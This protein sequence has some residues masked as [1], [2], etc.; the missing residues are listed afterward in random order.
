MTLRNASG[1]FSLPSVGRNKHNAH[2]DS[3]PAQSR[4]SSS[5]YNS[6]PAPTMT[7][8]ESEPSSPRVPESMMSGSTGGGGMGMGGGGGGGG[9]SAFDG[10]GRKLGKS[11]AHTSLLPSLGN[12]DLR[13]LQE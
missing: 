1:K 4:V 13:A 7:S 11:I 6:G 8:G 3:T 5:T 10:L 9:P 12:Q 2:H